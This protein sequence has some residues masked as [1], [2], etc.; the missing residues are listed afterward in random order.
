MIKKDKRDYL[1]VILDPLERKM[2]MKFSE[3]LKIN[4]F[5]KFLEGLLG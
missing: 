2:N 5:N 1:N 4:N 3:K